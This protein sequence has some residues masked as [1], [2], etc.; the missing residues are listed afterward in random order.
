LLH[1]HSSISLTADWVCKQKITSLQ[2]MQLN[3]FGFVVYEKK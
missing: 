1:F 3:N 2:K